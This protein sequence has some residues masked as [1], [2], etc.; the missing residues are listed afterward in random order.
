MTVA[1]GRCRLAPPGRRRCRGVPCDRSSRGASLPGALLVTAL[2][3]VAAW[4]LARRL[5]RVEVTGPSMRPS[6][7]PGDRLV[8]MVAPRWWTPRA[9]HVVA[10]GGPPPHR[11]LLVKRVARVEGAR[12]HVHGDDLE[13]STDSRSFGPVPRAAVVGP[14]V[15]RYWPPDRAGRLRPGRES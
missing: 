12:V 7:E 3:G 1:T 2:T 8:V 6:L 5:A 13:H 15:Y 14:A 11:R 10:V 4:V 9:G